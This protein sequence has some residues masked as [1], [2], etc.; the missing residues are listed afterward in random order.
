MY[1]VEVYKTGFFS[2]FIDPEKLAEKINQGT[3]GGV[4]ALDKLTTNTKGRI[5]PRETVF[6]IYSKK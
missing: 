5:F 3:Q 1:K 6:L 2:G 4:W